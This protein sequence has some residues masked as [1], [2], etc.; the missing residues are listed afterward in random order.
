MEISLFYG[1][2]QEPDRLIARWRTIA[3][4]PAVQVA[5]PLATSESILE[6]G[7]RVEVRRLRDGA[8]VYCA[9]FALDRGGAKLVTLVAEQQSYDPA[10]PPAETLRAQSAAELIVWGMRS[11]VP[12]TLLHEILI[13][14]PNALR[15][16]CDD[17]RAHWI[18]RTSV[19]GS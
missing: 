10:F 13:A 9:S 16:Q 6:P 4:R 8:L 3:D 19:P 14:H 12:V 5:V 1:R 18:A 17:L 2:G 7:W 15:S 11:Q